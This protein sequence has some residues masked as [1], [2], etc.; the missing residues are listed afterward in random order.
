MSEY[1]ARVQGL[2]SSH[3]ARLLT[4][5]ASQTAQVL[6]IGKTGG[7]IPAPDD[8][9]LRRVAGKGQYGQRAACA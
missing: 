8:E 7:R 5:I 9:T 2:A 6:K 4:K 3:H 1:A